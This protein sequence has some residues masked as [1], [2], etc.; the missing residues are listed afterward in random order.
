MQHAR[1]GLLVHGGRPLHAP[2]RLYCILTIMNTRHP[3]RMRV[4]APRAT[5]ANGLLALSP[6]IESLGTDRMCLT[7]GERLRQHAT[8]PLSNMTEYSGIPSKP[9]ASASSAM[10]LAAPTKRAHRPGRK[11][12]AGAEWGLLPRSG[13]QKRL[14]QK[15][16]S[17]ALIAWDSMRSYPTYALKSSDSPSSDRLHAEDEPA[18][19]GPSEDH[20][21]DRSRFA[22]RTLVCSPPAP[23]LDSSGLQDPP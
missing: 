10:A 22:I 16:L 18:R 7:A 17:M 23:I 4:L 20:R 15:R 1:C 8:T 6:P 9:G 2:S 12:V 5:N 11:V 19:Y 3:S 21:M 13:L 14:A